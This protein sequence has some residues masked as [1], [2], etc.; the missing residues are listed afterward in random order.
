MKTIILNENQMS[1]IIK[2]IL[3]EEHV[4][5]G[6]KEEVVKKWL[7]GHFKQMEMDIV[8]QNGLPIKQKVVSILD[9]NKQITKN[10]IDLKKLF[11]II[12]TQFKN[13][14]S[15]KKERDEFLWQTL[16]KWYK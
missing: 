3:K 9:T 11:F 16:N 4:Y 7:D 12:Q 14:L 1:F 10:I 15:D 2:Q 6:D 5:M 8:G 13:I